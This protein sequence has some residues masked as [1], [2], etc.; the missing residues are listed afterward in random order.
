MRTL[1][2]FL[3]L[4]ISAWS[5]AEP[6]KEVRLTTLQWP[7]YSGQQLAE[8][9]ASVA[10]A[11]AAFAAMGY[12]LHVDFFPWS[13]A[14]AQA[15]R[16]EA[17]VGYFPEYYSDEI[18]A[19]F[20]YS[21]PIGSGPLGFAEQKDATVSWSTLHDLRAFRIGVVQDYVNTEDFDNLAKAGIL[22]TEAVINDKSNLLKVISG[23][24]DLAVIDRNVMD[25]LLKTDP[26]LSAKT[27]KAHFNQRLLADKKLF[28]CFK[29]TPAGQRMAEIFNQGL[30]Q[31]DVDA[32]MAQHLH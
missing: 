27:H 32:I 1:A 21:H 30:K 3:T 14:V 23:R 10:V 11:K 22:Q 15:K 17:Y 20:I 16:D 6:D 19:D 13:R 31:I 25:Y 8:Q 2:I 18:A 9:G 26:A 7:P 12:Q 24:I 4:L 28:I 29:K 5:F